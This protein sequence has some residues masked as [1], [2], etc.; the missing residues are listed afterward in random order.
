MIALFQ[1]H[2][3]PAGAWDPCAYPPGS[4]EK[5]ECLARRAQSARR[6]WNHATPGGLFTPKR[7]KD[8][9]GED[10]STAELAENQVRRRPGR[11]LPGVSAER[12]GGFRA[13]LHVPGVGRR[14]LGHYPT[15]EAASQAVQE[16]RRQLA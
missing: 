2:S 4:P 9:T 1:P 7:G 16:A 14:Y 3:G 10:R 11:Y 8:V 12:N 6:L 13:R 5:I 15:E